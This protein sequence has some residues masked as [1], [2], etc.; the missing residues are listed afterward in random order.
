MALQC[1]SYLS[2][3][4]EIWMA[5]HWLDQC[6]IFSTATLDVYHLLSNKKVE[7]LIDD[8]DL[9][10]RSE[11]E[12]VLAQARNVTLFISS[13]FDKDIDGLVLRSPSVDVF[14]LQ[15]SMTVAESLARFY[16]DKLLLFGRMYSRVKDLE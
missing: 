16:D 15:R 8:A 10:P 6:L 12:S 11:L 13:L 5:A 3:D 4:G 14:E 7:V 2:V 1:I 9:I